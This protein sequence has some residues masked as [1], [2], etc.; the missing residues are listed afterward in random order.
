[1]LTKILAIV[2]VDLVLKVLCNTLHL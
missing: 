1:M 2:T